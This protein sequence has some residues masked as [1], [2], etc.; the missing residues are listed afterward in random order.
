MSFKDPEQ[1]KKNMEARFYPCFFCEDI[2]VFDLTEQ[3]IYL[4]LVFDARSSQSGDAY[5]GGFAI[6]YNWCFSACS[7]KHGPV[8]PSE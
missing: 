1:L 5:I 4:K 7:L 6:F 2:L 3:E 8:C